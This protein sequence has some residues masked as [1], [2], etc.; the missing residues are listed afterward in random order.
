MQAIASM[1]RRKEYSNVISPIFYA[2][3][4]FLRLQYRNEPFILPLLQTN[5]P[6]IQNVL[7]HPL[8]MDGFVNTD[9]IHNNPELF[10]VQRSQN[11][12]QKLLHYLGHVMVNGPVT[13]L[14]TGMKPAKITPNIP[15]VNSL[16][17]SFCH[18]SNLTHTI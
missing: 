14:S 16:Y 11:R 1:M 2:Y 18:C 17:P 13:P 3:I 9:F 8:F 6:F 10:D 4:Y 5:I 15:E 12:A 7:K